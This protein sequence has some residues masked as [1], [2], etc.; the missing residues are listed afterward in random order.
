MK[1]LLCLLMAVVLVFAFAA[2]GNSDK[3]DAS[4]PDGNAAT[5]A[6]SIKF[7]AESYTVGVEDYL[8]ISEHVTVEPAGA[9][10]VYSSSDETIAELSSVKGE[11]YGVKSGEVTVTAKSEDGKVSATCKLLVVGFGSI[12]DSDGNVGG[13]TNKRWGYSE[14]RGDA[15]AY[16]IIVPKNLED[17]TD[18]SKA[19]DYITTTSEK[20]G[21]GSCAVAV[22]GYYVAKTGDTCNYKIE[23]VPEGEYIGLII[24]SWDYT[25]K[26]DYDKATAVST[27]K[28]SAMGKYFSDA[29]INS[30]VSKFYEREF[31]VGELSVTTNNNTIFGYNFEP[32]MN[33]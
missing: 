5:V 24:S 3:D 21:D 16:V 9:K 14:V 2:C 17:G 28:A 4:K 12:V 23:N 20:A 7:D 10:V 29:E 32:D 8:M 11:F 27:F 30:L 25:T 33:K 31:Y 18:M 1:K 26:K 15:D 22:N 19:V 13:I 6:T